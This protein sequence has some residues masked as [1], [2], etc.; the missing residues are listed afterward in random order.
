MRRF[1]LLAWLA[2]EEE[3]DENEDEV[4]DDNDDEEKDCVR[5]NSMSGWRELREYA[6]LSPFSSASEYFLWKFGNNNSKSTEWNT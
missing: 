3:E 4:G 2:L 5:P 1:A 6:S